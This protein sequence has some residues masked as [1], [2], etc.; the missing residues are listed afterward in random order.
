[1]VTVIKKGAIKEEIEKAFSNLANT[2]KFN[3]Y[4]YCGTIKLTED[5]LTIQKKMRDEWE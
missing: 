1:M 3:A 2:K 4:K 5:P